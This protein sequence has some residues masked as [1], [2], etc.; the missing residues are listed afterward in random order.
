MKKA[1]LSQGEKTVIP[2]NAIEIRRESDG[3]PQV[4]LLSELSKVYS[5]EVSISHTDE[6]AIAVALASIS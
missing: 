6:Y 2:L 3:P 5:V 4:H 1:I